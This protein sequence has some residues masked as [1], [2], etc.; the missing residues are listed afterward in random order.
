MMAHSSKMNPAQPT[1]QTNHDRRSKRRRLRSDSTAIDPSID[2]IVPSR[3][4]SPIAASSPNANASI[5]DDGSDNSCSSSQQLFTQPPHIANTLPPSTPPPNRVFY[6]PA[7]P[8][9][10]A[11]DAIPTAQKEIIQRAIKDL[12]VIDTP[13]PF[14]IEAINHLAFS[15]DASLIVIR[16]TA[17]GKSLIPLA[18]SALRGGI[19][20]I[21]VPLHGLGSD[22]VDKAAIESKGVEAYYLDEHRHENAKILHDRL[23]AFTL[24]EANES[25]IILFVSPSSLKP[26][27]PWMPL[28]HQLATDGLITLLAI[29]E[30][31]A[32][33]QAGRSFRIEFTEA[34]TS[35]KSVYE[36]CP[37]PVPRLAMSATFRQEDYERV[38]SL[39]AILHLG[40]ASCVR[41]DNRVVQQ[42][43]HMQEEAA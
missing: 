1:P 42:T 35:M 20:L 30:A 31:H 37:R 41:G 18:T 34:V 11:I 4:H 13:R 17:D 25:T 6:A 43:T 29:D 33:E 5:N 23:S 28:F 19:S 38:V 7:P 3:T 32:I 24:D 14:Q 39:A 40:D 9:L 12:Y 27:S 2:R 22:Q 8:V 16:R 15:D 36:L 26:T 10:L 21:M